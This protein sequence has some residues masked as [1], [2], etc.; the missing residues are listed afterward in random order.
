LQQK[1]GEAVASES[2][3]AEVLVLAKELQ[4]EVE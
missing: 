2:L 4:R 3:E 1:E